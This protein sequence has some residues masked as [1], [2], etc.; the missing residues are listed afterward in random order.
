METIR[1]SHN[2][3]PS[4]D[5]NQHCILQSTILALKWPMCADVPLNH[6]KISECSSSVAN[7][8]VASSFHTAMAPDRPSRS[9]GESQRQIVDPQMDSSCTAISGPCSARWAP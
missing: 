3:L 4:T 9:R 5:F 6:I 7:A 2:L 1:L 8:I